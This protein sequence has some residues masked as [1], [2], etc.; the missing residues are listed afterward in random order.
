MV[1]RWFVIVHDTPEG[2]YDVIKTDDDDY[3]LLY[4]GAPDDWISMSSWATEAEAVEHMRWENA[5]GLIPIDLPDNWE[6]LQ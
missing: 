6:E 5:V 1:R 3:F 4:S 2:S